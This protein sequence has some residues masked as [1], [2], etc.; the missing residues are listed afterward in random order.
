MSIGVGDETTGGGTGGETGAATGGTETME[1]RVKR[2][3]FKVHL[4]CTIY[5]GGGTG[6]TEGRRRNWG[7]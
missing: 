1:E 4:F 6:G 5:I 7:H 3:R 2:T